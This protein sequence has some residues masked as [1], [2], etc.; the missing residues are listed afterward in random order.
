MKIKLFASILFFMLF[1]VGAQAAFVGF[2]V[3]PEYNMTGTIEVVD[4]FNVSQGVEAVDFYPSQGDFGFN[5]LTI[6]GTGHDSEIYT[7]PGTYT[8]WTT[9]DS[10][11]P[12]S[13]EISMTVGENQLGLRTFIDWNGN[14]YDIL[15]VWDMVMNGDQL[16]LISSD[17]NGDGIRGYQMVTGPFAGLNVIMDATITT[18]VPAAIWLFGS[19]LLCL[20][21]AGRRK[22]SS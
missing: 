7:S 10:V 1:S 6:A 18:P 19:G 3:P 20:I 2:P 22:L 16:S 14:T 15:T 9:P 8:F 11:F 4:N 17:M 5:Y 13:M 12:T 21:G